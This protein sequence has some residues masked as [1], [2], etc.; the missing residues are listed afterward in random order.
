MF[1]KDENLEVNFQKTA[2]E[3]T[4]Y[5]SDS[6]KGNTPEDHKDDMTTKSLQDSP[7]QISNQIRFDLFD[8]MFKLGK[9]QLIS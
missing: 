8:R 3:Q 4:G 5:K 2:K 9:Y 6:F 7:K 1:F